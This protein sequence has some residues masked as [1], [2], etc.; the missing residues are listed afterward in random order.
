MYSLVQ[1]FALGLAA[2]TTGSGLQASTTGNAGLSR[3]VAV[4]P[5]P[6]HVLGKN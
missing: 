6:L 3:Y 5:Q 4:R 2:L 1:L